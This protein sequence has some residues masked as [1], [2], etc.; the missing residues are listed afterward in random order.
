MN[1]IW[2]TLDELCIEIYNIKVN[3]SEFHNQNS[4]ENQLNRNQSASKY[5][6]QEKQQSL[7]EAAKTDAST[8]KFI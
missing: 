3:S 5:L 7:F 2:N 4:N 1:S 8:N 6:K